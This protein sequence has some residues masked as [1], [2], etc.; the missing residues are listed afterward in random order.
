MISPPL[1]SLALDKRQLPKGKKM[2][3]LL[4][5]VVSA[6]VAYVVACARVAGDEEKP[7]GRQVDDIHASFTCPTSVYTRCMPEYLPGSYRGTKH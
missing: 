7:D 1:A 5:P 2:R 6:H 3:R 4:F